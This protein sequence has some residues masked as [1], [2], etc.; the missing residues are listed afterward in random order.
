VQL[1]DGTALWV[2]HVSRPRKTVLPDLP[3]F[4]ATVPNDFGLLAEL[5]RGLPRVP[6]S[7]APGAG[8]ILIESSGG[9]SPPSGKRRL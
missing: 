1:D 4:P 7:V 6:T 2:G 3:V 9:A 8:G 5:A